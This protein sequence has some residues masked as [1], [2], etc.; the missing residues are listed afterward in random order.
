MDKRGSRGGGKDMGV[1]LNSRKYD[2]D[3]RLTFRNFKI[4][5]PFELMRP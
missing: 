2:A 3:F 4:I 5:L 1:V